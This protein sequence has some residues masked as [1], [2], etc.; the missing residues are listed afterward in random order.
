MSGTELAVFAQ[1]RWRLNDRVMF[2]LGLRVDRDDIVERVNYSPRGGVSFSVLP[3]GRGI[4]RGGV[5][6]FVSARRSTWARSRSTR[7]RP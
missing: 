5:G 2:E 6:K 7:R 4:L 3:E 1:D